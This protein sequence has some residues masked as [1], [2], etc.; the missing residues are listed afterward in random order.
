M[1]RLAA[2]LRRLRNATTRAD[3]SWLGSWIDPGHLEADARRAYRE[4]FAS[5]RRLVLKRFLRRQVA[6][7]SY[8]F[9]AHEAKYRKIHRLHSVPV[10]ETS[11]ELWHEA[12]ES[13][14]V[15][16]IGRLAGVRPEFR[17]SP[18]LVGYLKLC[19]VVS[20]SR[21]GAFLEEIT[22]TVLDR[23]ASPHVNAFEV[24]DCLTVH[25]DNVGRRRLAVIIY[26]SKG[27]DPGFGGALHMI[28]GE[29]EK[30]EAQYN[31]FVVFDVTA[32]NRHFVAPVEASAGERLRLALSVWGEGPSETS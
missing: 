27:W 24:G 10:N 11:E 5:R 17:L 26:L 1:E 7:E 8:Q 29:E 13:D 3:L 32:E 22:G 18:N 21:F 25:D 12:E 28:D 20:D 30:I 4:T 15:Y 31:S 23:L 2:D 14:R 19:A 9:L 6:D 16:R